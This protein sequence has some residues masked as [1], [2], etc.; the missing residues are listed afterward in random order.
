MSPRLVFVGVLAPMPPE[1]FAADVPQHT[2][3]KVCSQVAR[4][5]A[6]NYGHCCRWP[7]ARPARITASRPK[8]GLSKRTLGSVSH[9]RQQY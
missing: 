6:V 3:V 1:T 2:R 9:S 8:M 4:K 7:S 5:I